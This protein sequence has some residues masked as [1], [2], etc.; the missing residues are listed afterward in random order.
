MINV[1]ERFGKAIGD[2]GT[3]IVALKKY[4]LISHSVGVSF[5]IIHK[6]VF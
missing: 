2:G 6:A 5:I 3:V 4:G 1:R